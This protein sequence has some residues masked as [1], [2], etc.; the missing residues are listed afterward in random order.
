MK[1]VAVKKPKKMKTLKPKKVKSVK[2]KGLP[3]VKK[4]KHAGVMDPAGNIGTMA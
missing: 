3:K 1:K 2:A 4:P